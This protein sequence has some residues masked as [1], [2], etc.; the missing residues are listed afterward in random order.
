[1]DVRRED[2][3]PAPDC[4][5]ADLSF[6]SLRRA[7]AHIIGLTRE[8]WGVFLVKPQFEW[9]DP[10]PEFHGV[11]RNPLALLS[12]LSDLVDSLREEGVHFEGAVASPLRG[13]R[14]NREFLFRLRTGVNPRPGTVASTLEKL[15]L[16]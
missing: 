7:A 10:P 5:V 13:R 16:E 3:D 12:I 8:G 9:K 11:V 14:G 15:L 1:M 4:A 2:L 6:R